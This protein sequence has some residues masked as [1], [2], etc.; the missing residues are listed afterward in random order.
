MRSWLIATGAVASA[1]VLATIALAQQR[2]GARPHPAPA[3]PPAPST[4]PPPPPSTSVAAPSPG[5]AGA[6]P[7]SPVSSGAANGSK[8]SPLNPAPNE[9]SDAGMPLAPLDYDRLLSEL[10]S[11]RARA[12]AVS[13]V[14]FHSRLAITLQTSGEHARVASLTV[15]IDDGIVWSSTP[16]FRAED[17]T[18]VYDHS[19]APGRHAVT[20]DV[21]RHDDRDDT[22]RSWQKSRLV[23]DVPADGQ[24]SLDVKVEDDSS[25]GGDFR[26][27]QRGKYDLRVVAQAKSRPLAQGR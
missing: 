4:P 3:A 6:V 19:L 5:D 9:L 21:E 26:S 13:D 10:A 11:L 17:A 24:L 20:L 15:A 12:A 23:V 8:L 25:M 22:F 16:S 1:L 18:T 2:G 27:S 14:L 7:Q